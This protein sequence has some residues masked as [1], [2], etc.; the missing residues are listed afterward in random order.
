[1]DFHVTATQA[2]HEWNATRDDLP[3]LARE[4]DGRLASLFDAE[5]D[6]A[7]R[8]RKRPKDIA[9]ALLERACPWLRQTP[10]VS[11]QEAASLSHARDADV[12]TMRSYFKRAVREDPVVDRAVLHVGG[13]SYDL[14]RVT[15]REPA[16]CDELAAMDKL[17][18]TRH[19]FGSRRHTL[20]VCFQT[21]SVQ[22]TVLT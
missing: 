9:T 3:E 13:R 6:R 14:P 4:V 10:V 2:V 11:E 5:R 20:Q 16:S 12:D 1:M 18:P 17:Y 7:H 19:M 21:C 22:C 15:L 8:A